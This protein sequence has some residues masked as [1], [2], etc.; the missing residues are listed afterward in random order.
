MA[1]RR[2]EIGFHGGNI[3][4]VTLAET[5]VG[6]LTDALGGASEWHQV[7]AEEGKYWIKVADLQF[8]RI[9]DDGPHGV[10]FSRE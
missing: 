3:L 4:R 2:L 1:G 6:A 9:P 8:V 7:D 10:G 5:Q